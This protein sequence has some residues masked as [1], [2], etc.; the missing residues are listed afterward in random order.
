[1]HWAL[2]AVFSS[3]TPTLDGSLSFALSFMVVIFEAAY[4]VKGPLA[5]AWCVPCFPEIKSRCGF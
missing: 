1:M 3:I 2:S 5:R 4:P